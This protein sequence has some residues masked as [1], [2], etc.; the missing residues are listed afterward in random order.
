MR[1]SITKCKICKFKC[2]CK[3]EPSDTCGFEAHK[4]YEFYPYVSRAKFPRNG[5]YLAY[6]RDGF[7]CKIC[8]RAGVEVYS[9]SDSTHPCNL[10]CLCSECRLYLAVKNH[11]RRRS[12]D[13][14]EAFAR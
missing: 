3:N 9:I 12:Q 13:V 4:A 6:I 8:G 14:R 11:A 10:I 2:T 5:K 7:K 1:L